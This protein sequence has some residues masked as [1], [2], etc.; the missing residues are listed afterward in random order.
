M[1]RLEGNGSAIAAP[2]ATDIA[3]RAADG[4]LFACL[5]KL[6][7]KEGLKAKS[8]TSAVPAHSTACPAGALA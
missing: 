8:M 2:E 3:R 5:P 4:V 7:A 6:Q 1:T